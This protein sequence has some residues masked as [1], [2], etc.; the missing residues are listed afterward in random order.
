MIAWRDFQNLKTH[1]KSKFG[2]SA[3]SLKVWSLIWGNHP[4]AGPANSVTTHNLNE[5]TCKHCQ[6]TRV[7]RVTHDYLMVSH[8]H[9]SCLIFHTVFRAFCEFLNFE[10]PS[11]QSKVMKTLWILKNSILCNERTLE[12]LNLKVYITN[13]VIYK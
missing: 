11:T 8:E 3:G 9:T 4:R 7:T 6:L 10:N 2:Q 13:I 5:N 12:S 1:R